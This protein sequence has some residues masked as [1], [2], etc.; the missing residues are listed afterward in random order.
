M[1]VCAITHQLFV[2]EEVNKIVQLHPMT[3][4]EALHLAWQVLDEKRKKVEAEDTMGFGLSRQ[5]EDAIALLSRL[6]FRDII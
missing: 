2:M 5:Y 6:Y 3:Y 4:Q 1:V